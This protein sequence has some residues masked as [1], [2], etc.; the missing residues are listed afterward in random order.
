MIIFF[1]CY[2]AEKKI[3]A[4]TDE[5]LRNLSRLD[6]VDE[7]EEDEVKR[8]EA[9]VETAQLAAP[10]TAVLS[11]P[12][13]QAPV[14]PT[15]VRTAKAEKRLK[16]KLQR[17]VGFFYVKICKCTDLTCGA[18][19]LE[20]V[21]GLE[22]SEEE[23]QLSPAEQRILQA[24]K[25]AAWREAR[26]K[27]LEQDAMQAEMVIKKMSELAESN[28]SPITSLRNLSLSNA[29]GSNEDGNGNNNEDET[30]YSNNNEVSDRYNDIFRHD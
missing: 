21:Q 24:R 20:H 18:L 29:S 23:K 28:T 8:A 27:S 14:T 26:L 12:T 19:F 7:E 1:F 17:E 16:E 30:D 22:L 25:R 5:Q 10:A 11:A 6:D 15:V 4:L 9:A 3:A 13:S 2:R